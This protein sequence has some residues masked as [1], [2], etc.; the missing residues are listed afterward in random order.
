MS[1]Q[2]LRSFARSCVYH[3][4]KFYDGQ[5]SLNV[6]DL[7][8]FICE[9]FAALIMQNDDAR[10]NEATGSDNPLYKEK[11]LPALLRLLKN[12][13]DSDEKI[14]FI[15]AWCQGV[16]DYQKVYMQELI[17]NAIIDYNADYVP[18]KSFTVSYPSL[19]NA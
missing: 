15:N 2:E 8:D 14:E 19:L 4:A 5:Y 7:D 12:S 3:Y 6:S 10:A 18:I 17:D 16:S 9:E 13:S 1:I 11:M